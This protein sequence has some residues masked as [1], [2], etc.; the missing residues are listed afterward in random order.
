MCPAVHIRKT[1]KL[2]GAAAV[3]ACDGG[4][5]TCRLHVYDK[6][7][8]QHFL[9][10]TGAEVSVIPPRPEDKHHTSKFALT[11]ANGSAISTYGERYLELDFALRRPYRWNFIIADVTNA[12]IGA[13]FLHHH[14]L[15]VHLRS[16]RIVD[17]ETKLSIIAESR[18]S[19]S[20]PI[21]LVNPN[22]KYS[23]LLNKFPDLLRP[24]P[25][26]LKAKHAVQHH[27]ITSG[28]PV[29]S[30]PR[31]L[32]LEKYRQAKEEFRVMMELG[33]CRPSSSPW[34]SPLH[35]VSKK[36]GA[37]RPCGDYRRLNAVT[38]PD[39]Y[40]VPHLHDFSHILSNATIFTTLDLTRAYNQIPVADEDICKTAVITPFGLYEFPVMSFGLCNAAQTFQR[41][42]NSTLQ[43]LNFVF[44]YIDDLLIASTS[45]EEHTKHLGM[46]FQRLSNAGIAINISKCCFGEPTV[47]F[48]GYQLTAQGIQPLPEKVK[49]IHSIPKPETVKDL[50]QFL[51]TINFYRRFTPNAALLQAPLNS[52]ITGS[53]KNDR[54]KIDWTDESEA[55]FQ[56]CKQALADAVLI[57][58]PQENAELR[59]VSDASDVAIG[60]ALEQFHNNAWQPLEFFSR[61]LTTTEKKY[62]AYDREL[63]GIYCAVKHFKHIIEGRP[64]AIKTDHKPLIFAFQ[65]KPEKASPRQYR[66]L[67]FISQFSTN[68]THIKGEDNIVADTLSRISAIHLPNTIDY[69]KLAQAQEADEN[70]QNLIKANES[71]KFQPLQFSES[72]KPIYC[73]TSTSNIRP[74]VPPEF[75]QQVFNMLHNLSHPGSRA[76]IKLITQK[77]VWPG[78]SS[79]IRQ[80]TR[81]CIPCQKS[82]IQRHTI[83]PFAS[84]NIPSDRFHH[85]NIDIIGPLPPSNGNMY[86][87]TAIDRFTRWTEAMPMSDITTE[88]VI[89]T[90]Y[91]G[92][93]VR[94]GVPEDITTDQ[95]RQF[96]S[97]SFKKFLKTF[98]IKHHITSAYH[99][100]AN[101][102]IERWHR[103]LKAAL[104]AYNNY[105]WTETLPSVLLGLRTTIKAG[106]QFS[107]A[108]MVYGTTIRVPGELLAPATT[109]VEPTDLLFQMQQSL[110]QVRSIPM[111]NHATPAFFVH[112]DLQTCTHIF[113]R[114]DSH[115]T[116]LQHPYDG[117][118]EVV[119]REG[120]QFIIR[121]RGIEQAVSIDRVKPAY[122][123]NENLVESPEPHTMEF[124][125]N[126]PAPKPPTALPA[127]TPESILKQPSL[128]AEAQEKLPTEDNR[129]QKKVRF[130]E[131]TAHAEKRFLERSKTTRSGR[132]TQLPSRFSQHLNAI[133]TTLHSITSILPLV[134]KHHQLM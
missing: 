134:S 93:I 48:L 16:K 27:I 79:D 124:A 78:M 84:H 22:S 15:S 107:P 115:R 45:E 44:A 102:V 58:I 104:K 35:M 68:I 60:A 82:K 75:R 59:I 49:A 92:W 86:C 65:Q 88:T 118:Y 51:G 47:K 112:P 14:N 21:Y 80:W 40:P 5:Q 98:G 100:Q 73:D 81:A 28:P 130:Q 57:A 32:P 76:S 117:P 56:A 63:L 10:D 74:Y 23:T 8:K 38:Q 64:L 4:H 72:E 99:P 19:A 1:G 31:R 18:Y 50:R 110:Q 131:S 123:L 101:G 111:T 37:W 30:R 103:T 39:R 13:D 94:F 116:P 85:I 29:C 127:T 33:I 66:Q 7:T 77:F 61:K 114:H 91:Q 9:V 125:Y 43:G 106:T 95:G 54:T 6:R 129:P 41:F 67:Q 62:S 25:V 133:Q 53:K 120:K 71:L 122:F 132:T 97:H 20:Q 17:S 12:I 34:A 121:I 90:F 108:E 42:I 126:P 70:L 52:F 113:L 11:A 83:S 3:A 2:S 96:V 105:R 119:R 87:L 26:P 89:S 36:Q 128:P 46:V 24:S 109:P 69:A 55:A